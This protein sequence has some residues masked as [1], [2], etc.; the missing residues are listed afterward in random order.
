MR[1]E[2]Q[3][4]LV[5]NKRALVRFWGPES[6]EES[7]ALLLIIHGLGEHSGR[8]DKFAKDLVEKNQ[9]EILCFDLP[10][11]GETS[12][13]RGY[14]SKFEDFLELIQDLKSSF[15]NHPKP[16]ILFGHSL[17]G[18][19]AVRY[20]QEH[21]SDF[22]GLILSSPA[23]VFNLDNKIRNIIPILRFLNFIIPWFTTSN[24]LEPS[25]LS[26]NQES[27]EKYVNDPLV[28]DRISIRLFCEMLRNSNQAKN[29]IERIRIPILLFGGTDDRIVS[30]NEVAKL[31]RKTFDN[32]IVGFEGGYHELFEDIEHHHSLLKLISS[33]IEN[34]IINSKEKKYA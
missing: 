14:I 21:E 25:S 3:K 10:G 9:I 12:G 6:P 2:K 26:R 20:V 17:G 1:V 22:D 18:L 27:V 24:G 7:R 33:W 23:I 28:H 11:H 4:A 32:Q 31:I 34:K 29:G 15:L 19:I 16:R 13:L 30:F 8:Y 5:G